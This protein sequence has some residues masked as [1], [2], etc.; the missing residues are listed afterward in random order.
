MVNERGLWAKKDA[1][2]LGCSLQRGR[3]HSKNL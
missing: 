2:M 1:K 3:V